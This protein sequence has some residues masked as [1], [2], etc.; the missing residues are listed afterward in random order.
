MSDP[1]RQRQRRQARRGQLGPGHALDQRIGLSPR[2]ITF[3]AAGAMARLS[4]VQQGAEL[5]VADIT[6]AHLEFAGQITARLRRSEGRD[7]IGQ[8]VHVGHAGSA[9]YWT[10]SRPHAVLCASCVAATP[11]PSACDRCRRADPPLRRWLAAA[12]RR[13]GRPTGL[14]VIAFTCRRCETELNPQPTGA[15]EAPA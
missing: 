4:L 1:R 9:T 2:E 6:R 13:D 14:V 15:N 10:P 3:L 12:A 8:C 5:Q 11:R 7:Q